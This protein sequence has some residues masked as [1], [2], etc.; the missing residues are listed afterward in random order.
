MKSIETVIG[1]I[2]K[3]PLLG[4]KVCYNSNQRKI[5]FPNPWQGAVCAEQLDPNPTYFR[6]FAE[7]REP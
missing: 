1:T 3:M 7:F 4:L 5:N 2:M 6:S